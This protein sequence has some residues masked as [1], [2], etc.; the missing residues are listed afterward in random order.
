MGGISAS[1]QFSLPLMWTASK[2]EGI[3]LF[4]M[5]RLISFNPATLAGL[6]H[7]KVI[8]K[9]KYLLASTYFVYFLCIVCICY[10]LKQFSIQGC[11]LPGFDADF[12]IWDPNE[13]FTLDAED[14][15]CRNKDTS[16]YIGKKLKGV[17]KR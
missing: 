11:I 3:S 4:E 14:I 1:L 16:P 8:K 7:R 17:V 13:N 10:M 15:L 5:N 6:E 2:R 9:F 12:V